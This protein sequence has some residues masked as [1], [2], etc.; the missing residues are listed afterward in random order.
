MNKARIVGLSLLAVLTF[1][2]N[3]FAKTEKQCLRIHEEIETVSIENQ[4]NYKNNIANEITLDGI[5]YILKDIKQKE[6]KVSLTK[7]KEEQEQKIVNTGNKYN[8]LSSFEQEI[9]VEEDGYS[10]I[11][12]LQQDSINLVANESYMEEYKVSLKKEYKNVPQNELN[13]IPKTIQE[14][15]ITYY[16][17]NPVWNVA[18]TD[19]L[20]IPTSYN[21]IMNY[22]GV[23]KRRV[24]KNYLATV[25]YKGTL[26]R[27]EVE[28]ITYNITYEGIE[29]EKQNYTPIIATT[30]ASIIFFSGI[31]IFKRKNIIIYNNNYGKW[32]LVKKL[33][34]S[35]NDRLID[36]TPNIPMSSKYKIVLNT[37]LYNNLKNKRVTLKYFDKQ[38]IYEIK[39]KE[40]EIYV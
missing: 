29:I 32:I 40:F 34:I 38:Y 28:S 36:I 10:G 13:D 31:I 15:G 7:D 26:K 17:I 9:Q 23:T 8:A 19:E 16:L 37:K 11:I 14:N 3:C 35:I 25:I 2:T 21:G 18:S 4:Y 24:I 20:G 33:S 22:E 6:N 5:K 1:S 39:E 12:E 27:E 30:T